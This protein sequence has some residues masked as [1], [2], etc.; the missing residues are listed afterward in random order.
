MEYAGFLYFSAYFPY[1]FNES[2]STGNLRIIRDP[3]LRRE[4]AAYYNLIDGPTDPM[5]WRQRARGS[6]F[7]T[8][9]GQPSMMPAD[10]A[11]R[12][13]AVGMSCAMYHL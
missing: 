6:T 1:T 13:R 7:E 12:A 5:A 9:S 2:V 3:E 10:G 11:K 4:I 8:S